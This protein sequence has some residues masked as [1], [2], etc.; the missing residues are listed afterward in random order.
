MD[1]KITFVICI[2]S[3][4][5]LS[6][7]HTARILGVFLIPSVSHLNVF[8]SY[9][10]ELAKQGHEL[11]IIAPGPIGDGNLTN[12]TEIDISSGF[13]NLIA[14]YE[15]YKKYQK[16]GVILDV[17]GELEEDVYINFFN[18]MIDGLQHP[19]IEK[20]IDDKQQ[21]FDL[22][23][24]EAFYEYLLIF[25]EIFKA[26]VIMIGSHMGFPDHYKMV[27]TVG[28]HP[29]YYP[30][31]Q[32]M[33]YDNLGGWGMLKEI[34]IEYKF[35]KASGHLEEYQN[36]LLKK[37]FGPETPTISQLKNNVD[38]LFLSVHPMIGNNRPV[39]PNVIFF[40]APHLLPIKDLPQ[41]KF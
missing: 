3:V 33:Y 26:P 27:G 6:N 25:S 18:T 20:L 22:I 17:E 24:I 37:N 19:A 21:K 8:R 9:T 16:R 4:Y 39:P 15:G 31:F 41:V 36:E 11:V 14:I 13:K 38:M 32:R 28:T 34:Y 40:H 7:V 1:V 29:V 30:F 23:V 2:V 5:I 12:I 10:R 35:Y